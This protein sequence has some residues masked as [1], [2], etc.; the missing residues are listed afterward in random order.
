LNMIEND[1]ADCR[2]HNG[3]KTSSKERLHGCS[4]SETVI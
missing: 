1:E 4:L 3:R 2:E